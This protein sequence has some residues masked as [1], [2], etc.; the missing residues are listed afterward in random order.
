M[1]FFVDGGDS[2]FILFVMVDVLSSLSQHTKTDWPP[3]K[4]KNKT[5]CRLFVNLAMHI[6]TLFP[7]VH[8]FSDLWNKHSSGCSSK[9]LLLKR[10]IV[11]TFVE[12]RYGVA[13]SSFTVFWDAPERMDFHRRPRWLV[14]SSSWE[15]TASAEVAKGGAQVSRSTAT[16]AACHEFQPTLQAGVAGAHGPRHVHCRSMC[17]GGQV[18]GE[19]DPAVS[20]LKEALRVAQAQCQARPVDQRIEATQEFIV[21]TKKR[22]HGA[23]EEVTRAQEAADAATAKLR[24]EEESLQQEEARLGSLQQEATGAQGQA[25]PPVPSDLVDELTHLRECVNDLRRERDELR[26]QIDASDRDGR[27]E[28]RR[29]SKSL[30]TPSLDLMITDHQQTVW[31]PPNSVGRH[32]GVVMEADTAIRGIRFDPL[33]HG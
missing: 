5:F 31:T 9:P 11:H 1:R 17:Q 16:C 8:P 10:H 12:A 27:V 2:L 19:N 4:K 30:A 23:P 33:V 20:F 24:N 18:G 22:I 25:P 14:A 32:P 3:P 29:K 15:E 26:S 28:P 7:N 6:R 13:C 21:R